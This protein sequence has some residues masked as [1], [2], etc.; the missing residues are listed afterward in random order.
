MTEV[1]EEH[2][3]PPGLAAVERVS[4]TDH[5]LRAL[6]TAIV[7]GAIRQGDQLRE[8]QL[9][10]SLGTGRGPVR[11]ALRQ[12]VQEGLAQHEVHRGIFVRHIR[13]EDVVD[14]YRAREAVEAAAAEL[15]IAAST[16]LAPLRSRVDEMARIAGAGGTWRELS[17][18]D[19]GFHETLVAL[20]GSDRLVRMYA[21]LAAE[22]R[23]HLYEYPPYS[24]EQTVVDHEEIAAALEAR[25]ARAVDLLRGHLRYSAELAAEWRRRGD[26]R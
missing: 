9:A 1:A 3:G 15:L 13:A 7:S 18:V 26:G 14:V 6:R 8:V 25:D 16:D 2:P 10:A 4:T 17:D 21:T 12:L 24:F 20:S 22:S 23:M 11:E 5:V 19:I